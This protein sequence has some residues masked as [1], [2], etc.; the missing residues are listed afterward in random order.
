[1]SSE[2][3]LFTPAEVNALVPS[4]GALIERLQRCAL[5]LQAEREAHGGPAKIE[6]VATLV[7]A[8]PGARRLVEDMDG[9]VSE[10]GA[11][12]GQ[13]KDL[14][15]GLVD[16]P[17]ELRGE[18]VLLCWQFGEPEVAFWHHGG[19]GFAGR[20]RLPGRRQRPALQ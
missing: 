15:L 8:R 17:G 10:I 6:D 3:R 18:K 5:A 19:E 4:L 11:M 16:F 1:V 20:R 13:L 2:E 14:A 9:I 7:R 12:G